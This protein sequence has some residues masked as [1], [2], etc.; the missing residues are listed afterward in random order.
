MLALL[1][2]LPVCSFCKFPLQ[3]GSM[4]ATS[5]RA[6]LAYERRSSHT[7]PLLLHAHRCRLAC[8]CQRVLAPPL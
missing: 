8:Y 6:Q 4:N 2:T 3:K 7:P 1:P 5:S